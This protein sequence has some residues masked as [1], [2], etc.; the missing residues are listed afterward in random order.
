MAPKR[1][2]LQALCFAPRA[3]RAEGTTVLKRWTTALLVLSKKLEAIF[4]KGEDE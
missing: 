2:S 4:Q 3:G 1:R